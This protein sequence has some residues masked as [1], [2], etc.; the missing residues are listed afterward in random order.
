MSRD[1]TKE[2]GLTSSEVIVPLRYAV[3]I[4]VAVAVVAW[5]GMS[6]GL[7]EYNAKRHAPKAVTSV[8]VFLR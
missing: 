1:Y 8:Q 3:P 7:A 5:Y 6:A 2:V 4:L